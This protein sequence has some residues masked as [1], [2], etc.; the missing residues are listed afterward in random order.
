MEVNENL[1]DRQ[2]DRQ[3]IQTYTQVHRLHT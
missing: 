2:T 3:F 1:T